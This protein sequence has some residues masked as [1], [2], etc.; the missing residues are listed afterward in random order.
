MTS[1]DDKG[2]NVTLIRG[3]FHEL[4]CMFISVSA[5]STQSSSNSRPARKDS[6]NDTG[7]FLFKPRLPLYCR[8]NCTFALLITD[9]F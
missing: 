1:C 9:K 4:H 8:V 2:C 7:R 3:D 5:S 6:T